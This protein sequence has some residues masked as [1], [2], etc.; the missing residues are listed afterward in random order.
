MRHDIGIYIHCTVIEKTAHGLRA[1]VFVIGI[2][3]QDI[4]GYG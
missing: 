4:S 2:E 3:Q 1:G